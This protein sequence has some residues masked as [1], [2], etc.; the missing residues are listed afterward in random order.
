MYK[1]L[2]QKASVFVSGKIKNPSLNLFY[3]GGANF[4]AGL[5]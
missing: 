3:R 4:G 1:M 2:Q 5:A